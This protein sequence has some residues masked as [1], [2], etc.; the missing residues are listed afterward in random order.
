VQANI[1]PSLEVEEAGAATAQW[2]EAG[3][4]ASW[5]REAG[6][7]DA[8]QREAGDAVS[9][10]PAISCP[11]EATK[12]CCRSLMFSCTPSANTTIL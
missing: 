4:A 3:A 1:Y 9:P 6:A 2:R 10:V 7:G 11:S 8:R 12:C 5:R